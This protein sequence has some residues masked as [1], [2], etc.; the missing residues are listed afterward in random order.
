MSRGYSLVAVLIM[1]GGCAA[2]PATARPA[3]A[4][5]RPAPAA[6][7]LTPAADP[8]VVSRFIS[9]GT[10]NSHV[11]ADLGYLTDVIGPRLTGS[12]AMQRASDWAAQ[13]FREYGLDSVWTEPWAFGR[14][15]ERGPATVRI[16]EPQRR[17]LLGVSWAWSPGTKGPLA[18]DV[19]LIDARSQQEFDRRFAGRLRGAWVMLGGAYAIINSDGPPLALRDSMRIDSLRRSLLPRTEDEARFMNSRVP[20]VAKEGVAGII[21]EGGKQFALL[22]MSGSPNVISPVPQIVVGNETYA[23][24]QRL[25]QRGERV[26]IEADLQNR[27]GTDPLMQLNTLAELRGSEKPD[28]VVLLGAHLDSWDLGTG[29]TDNG[30]GAIAVLEAARILK[31]AGVRPKRTIRFALFSGEEQGLLGSQAYAAAHEPELAKYQ[32]VL[33]L[34]NGTGRINAMALQGREDLRELWKGLLMPVVSL[35]PFLVRSGNKTGTDHLSFLPYGVPGFN[36][37]QLTR[38][39]DHTHHSQV[40]V[41]DHAV[42]SD[43]AQAATVMAV[44]AWELADLAELLPRGRKE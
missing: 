18:G 3:P 31:A 2:P 12:A 29:A 17:E 37:D 25:I 11:E 44:N 22:T 40:D 13:K 42:P 26:R 16:L 35:G 39:Y 23:Q 41:F 36:Y 9:E 34:D 5:A 8:G 7:A 38:G 30:T 6:A 21:R 27:F 14:G 1:A 4:P 19:V 20:L 43:V 32:A 10:K 28:E 33:V 15:W 24:F